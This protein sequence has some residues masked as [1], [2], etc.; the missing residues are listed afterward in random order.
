MAKAWIQKGKETLQNFA[1][2]SVNWAVPTGNTLNQKT[3]VNK[4]SNDCSIWKSLLGLNKTLV[5]AFFFRRTAG[6]KL[7][8]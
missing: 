2:V 3:F 5:A 7:K 1:L 8:V 4:C 6:F